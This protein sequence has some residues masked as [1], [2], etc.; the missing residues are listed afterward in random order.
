MHESRQQRN[1]LLTDWLEPEP[2]VKAARLPTCVLDMNS[3]LKDP[4]GQQGGVHAAQ[5]LAQQ[6]A[7]RQPVRLVPGLEGFLCLLQA[8]LEG[9]NSRHQ[10]SIVEGCGTAD[11]E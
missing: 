9:H 5:A 10:R 2:C 4:E 8:D 3:G 6:P 1:R 11:T 7:G